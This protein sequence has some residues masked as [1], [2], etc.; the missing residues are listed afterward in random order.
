MGWG[1]ARSWI[2]LWVF[3]VELGS[4]CFWGLLLINWA[5][6]S[7]FCEIVWLVQGFVHLILY[8][9]YIYWVLLDDIRG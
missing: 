9:I 2:G 8:S 4:G 1:L 6:L 7:V 3:G 5:T